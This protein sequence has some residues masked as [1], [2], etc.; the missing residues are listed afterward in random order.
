[1]MMMIVV[2]FSKLAIIRMSL[3]SSFVSLF[4]TSHPDSVIDRISIPSLS[5]YFLFGSWA[6]L[7]SSENVL[8]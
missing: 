6:I 8:L 7:E 3:S 4:H 5:S 2:C 1:M